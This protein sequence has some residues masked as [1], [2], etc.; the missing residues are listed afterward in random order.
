MDEPTA[1]S[2]N[3]RLTLGSTW[4]YRQRLGLEEGFRLR[5]TEWFHAHARTDSEVFPVDTKHEE[6][7]RVKVDALAKKFDFTM[8][9][10]DDDRESMLRDM[11]DLARMMS[12]S[13]E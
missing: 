7:I 11:L 5:L 13:V 4:T 9:C 2:L 8:R 10:K 6:Q 12:V 3:V 1:F